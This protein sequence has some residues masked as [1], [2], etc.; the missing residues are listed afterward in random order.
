MAKKSKNDTRVEMLKNEA[1]KSVE[2]VLKKKGQEFSELSKARK[3]RV[4]QYLY[5]LIDLWDEFTP[6]RQPSLQEFT[7]KHFEEDYS[8]VVGLANKI[9]VLKAIPYASTKKV[10]L[11]FE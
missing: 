10:T 6:Q 8:Q 9:E 7:K 2:S 4:E 11:V 3:Y 1:M 5:A